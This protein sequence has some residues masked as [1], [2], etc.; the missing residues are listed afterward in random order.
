MVSKRRQNAPKTEPKTKMKT[1]NEISAA[2]A[3]KLFIACCRD[4]APDFFRDDP[5]QVNWT[6]P[7]AF[8]KDIVAGEFLDYLKLYSELC[9]Y[10]FQS[11]Q[12]NPVSPNDEQRDKLADVAADI[13]GEDLAK[14]SA[15]ERKVFDVFAEDSTLSNKE[16]GK[17]LGIVSST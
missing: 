10:G 7:K 17:M 3:A 12:H 5:Y 1:M 9:G 15:A 13:T 2:E 11:E 16:I 14:L 4:L 8:P 6:D